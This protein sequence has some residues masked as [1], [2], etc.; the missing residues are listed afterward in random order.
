MPATLKPR[1]LQLLNFLIQHASPNETGHY[2]TL[3]KAG[4][5]E[6]VAEIYQSKSEFLD[7]LMNREMQ[8]LRDKGWISM[9]EAVYTV[10]HFP[11]SS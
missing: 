3:R 2:R 5:P 9:Q 4:V 6:K 7:S 8:K 10:L 11:E 1:E